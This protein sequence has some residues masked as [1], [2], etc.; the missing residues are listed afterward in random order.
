M[1]KL[2]SL[3]VV[4][5]LELH[6][7]WGPFQPKPFC[8]SM[9]VVILLIFQWK[10]NLYENKFNSVKK[11]NYL[12]N[13][14]LLELDWRDTG[15]EAPLCLRA[16]HADTLST[17]VFLSTCTDA[18]LCWDR[19]AAET[20]AD[21]AVLL[22]NT[23]ERQKI[24]ADE[25]LADLPLSRRLWKCKRRKR[26]PTGRH[27]AKHLPHGSS[28]CSTA[29]CALNPTTHKDR[30]ICKTEKILCPRLKAEEC[31]CCRVHW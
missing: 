5:G 14:C 28:C 20:H 27:L 13:F 8:D 11:W 29:L 9:K 26:L 24:Q 16:V 15:W 22:P 17:R 3:P 6:D 1:W 2:A 25:G 23:A 7:P 4:G 31:V 21:R 18:C 30:W 19:W 12:N 10:W